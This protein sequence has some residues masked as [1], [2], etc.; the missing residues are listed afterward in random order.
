M[1]FLKVVIDILS[2]EKVTYYSSA[3]LRTT[4]WAAVVHAMSS[5]RLER[6]LRRSVSLL[7]FAITTGPRYRN[8][9]TDSGI[10]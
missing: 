8:L 3:A 7:G 4:S 9:G 10:Q 2:V 1:S 5:H 6:L